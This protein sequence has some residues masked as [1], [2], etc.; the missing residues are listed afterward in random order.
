[1]KL[2]YDDHERKDRSSI[3]FGIVCF[4]A[5]LGCIIGMVICC[6]EFY[7]NS[8][9][10]N[11][12]ASRA[13]DKIVANATTTDQELSK[14]MILHLEKIV[15]IQ[16]SGMKNDLM[17][18]VYGA[19]STILVGLCAG[20]VAKSRENADKA[21]NKA[22]ETK[23]AIDQAHKAVEIATGLQDRLRLI[24]IYNTELSA[25]AALMEDNQ[26]LANKAFER[27]RK[28]IKSLCNDPDFI[29]NSIVVGEDEIEQVYDELLRLKEKVDEI[30]Q[31]FKDKGDPKSIS[32]LQSAERYATLIDASLEDLD[33]IRNNSRPRRK[34]NQKV[35]HISTSK[36]MK[37][38]ETKQNKLSRFF[39]KRAI[40]DKEKK[41]N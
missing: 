4:I 16:E 10:F 33:S 39:R 7:L 34:S 37:T 21:E 9:S 19:L 20:F 18:F 15:S 1:M 28:S 2:K 36:K 30:L 11:E 41:N 13:I 40:G 5:V 14:E 38:D 26:V 17:S 22:R 12:E 35:K 6:V 31:T 27:I 23:N 25:M 3:L 32:L 29:T 24:I 8:N